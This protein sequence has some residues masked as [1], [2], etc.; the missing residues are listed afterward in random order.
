M[1]RTIHI[2]FCMVLCLSM[3]VEVC[4]V[5][6]FADNNEYKGK[7]FTDNKDLSDKLDAI[8]NGSLNLFYDE[9]C[10]NPVN[11]SLGTHAVR[12]GTTLYVGP[13]NGRALNSGETCWI[14]ANAVYYTLFNEVTGN[15]DPGKNSV[16]LDISKTNTKK[17]SFSNFQEWGV[18]VGTGTLVRISTADWAHSFIILDYN[19]ESVVILDGNGDGDGLVSITNLKWEEVNEAYN[20]KGDVM[21]IIQPK[22]DYYDD[23][24]PTYISNCTF[25][26]STGEIEIINKTNLKSLP[27]SIKTCD[28]SNALTSCRP[29]DTFF[30]CGLYRNTAGNYWYKV[31][32]GNTYGYIYAGDAKFTDAA[33]GSRYANSYFS[34]IGSDLW[35]IDN[36][37]NSSPVQ[38]D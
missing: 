15:G 12:G 32:T 38:I 4:S 19:T 24:Y 30:V 27:C 34:I 33:I 2:F 7:Q 6:S 18:R 10:T 9:W 3:L 37:G 20:F 21:Y 25:Y 35:T 11:A 29:G 28:R 8:F 1:K 13:Q 5:N 31:K 26:Q 23:L 36:M 16:S 17:M 22:D 14:Y